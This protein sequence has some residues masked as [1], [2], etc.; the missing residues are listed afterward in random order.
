M[1][2]LASILL[3]LRATGCA[4][5]LCACVGCDQEADGINP[6]PINTKL[7][8]FATGQKK[9]PKSDKDKNKDAGK[10]ADDLRIAALEKVRDNIDKQRKVTEEAIK[11][12]P[13]PD[14]KK[15]KEAKF[16]PKA[17]KAFATGNTPFAE[18][19]NDP[20]NKN[21]RKSIQLNS[22]NDLN[23]QPTQIGNSGANSLTGN[24]T[25][26]INGNS[27]GRGKKNSADPL[28][29]KV[30][31][32]SGS[33][34]IADAEKLGQTDEKPG[35]LQR[36]FG[37][38][39]PQK[40]VQQGPVGT[41]FELNDTHL[42]KKK[43]GQVFSEQPDGTSMGATTKM[44]SQKL[45][46]IYAPGGKPEVPSSAAFMPAPAGSQGLLS[47]RIANEM[48]RIQTKNESDRI[49]KN[50]QAGKSDAPKPVIENN[51]PGR[52]PITDFEPAPNA[53][54]AAR[55]AAP[56][57]TAAAA[58]TGFNA[59]DNT[60]ITADSPINSNFNPAKFA[61][62]ENTAKEAPTPNPLPAAKPEASADK[63][64]AET[65]KEIGSLDDY[66]KGLKTRDI[67]A[68]EAAFQRA[69]AEKRL[70]A[71]PALLDEVVRNGMLAVT[72]ARVIAVIGKRDDT[73]DHALMVGLNTNGQTDAPLREACAEALG[74]LR[75]RRAVPMLIEKA[76]LE[77]NFSV[78]SACVGALGMIGD[79]SALTTLHM[80]LDD[81]GEIE[82]VKQSAA[83]ALA[84]F[85]DP[86][87]REHLIQSLESHIPAYQVLGLTG[88]AQ[89]NDPRSPGYLISALD[90]RFDEVWTTAVM[91]FPYLGARFALPLLKTQLTSPNDVM[92]LRSSL[93]L[94]YLG[95]ADGVPLICRATTSGSLQERAMG[96]E[97][98]GRLGRMD[99]IP[100][101]ISKLSDPNTQVRTTA[102]SA[103]T[104]LDAQ[105]AIPALSEA[106]RGRFK[107]QLIQPT[108]LNS[109]EPD[110]GGR[111]NRSILS[112][113]LGT[114]QDMNE[115]MILLA[116]LR[117]L[118]G[119]KDNFV[120]NTLPNGRDSSWPEFD[121]ELLKQQIDM[122]KLFKLVDVI[123][124]GSG[125]TGAMIQIPGA[126]ETLYRKG[127][128]IAG[129]FK[130]AE[131]STGAPSSDP[132][133]P[134]PP[135]VSLMR[136]DQRIILY[137]GQAPEVEN[138]RNGVK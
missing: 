37:R 69:A 57:A 110:T 92:R 136:G 86:A 70:D 123:P 88:L 72:A 59:S 21:P 83:L 27:A 102:A 22:P 46:D 103:L 82:F 135:F 124:S 10:T 114:P 108:R 94:G 42:K 91:L 35:L 5:L 63:A 116:C 125:A 73:I 128:V 80:K 111:D 65:Q 81:R 41:Q 9:D 28:D 138:V 6:R 95:C 52:H 39:Q 24:N 126:P 40:L 61:V 112:V 50:A 62:A 89:L 119:E 49:A 85:G 78:R 130:V 12:G 107:N 53:K 48:L 33:A 51:G 84:R 17:P 16:D 71:L 7:S 77:K 23:Q 13:Q 75:V 8:D 38:T 11:K 127:E 66:R 117:A 20:K 101:L 76:K 79:E 1:R 109:N 93:A 74:E 36:L 19:P 4:A 44:D 100:L 131:I 122:I 113:Q 106:A 3:V 134:L 55:A 60:P 120:L 105:D 15:D 58:A 99:Q 18:L 104:R 132:Q 34:Q 64:I 56:A 45:N 129:G 14:K 121:R 137:I 43:L 31:Q 96:C 32:N 118:R 25:S 97:L 29:T 87:G 133:K 2:P 115:R 47:S 67:V 90:S 98:L 54:N 30:L 68:R 26:V